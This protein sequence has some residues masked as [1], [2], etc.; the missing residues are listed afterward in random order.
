MG[1]FCPSCGSGTGE[2]ARFCSKCGYNLIITD[3]IQTASGE[4]VERKQ[5]V[6]S[7]S[8]IETPRGLKLLPGEILLERHLDYYISNKRLIKHV[9][10]LIS[11]KTEDWLLHHIKGTQ[12]NEDKPFLVPGIGIGVLCILLSGLNAM[13]FFFGLLAII[14]AL[15]YKTSELEIRHM[16]GSSFQIPDIHA[17]GE[18]F[19]KTFKEVFYKQGPYT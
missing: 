8:P 6:F 4:I 14:V 1:K 19:L 5:E 16:D 3:K 17:G 2:D 9:P 11:S 15:S 13:F 10:S 18:N 12:L 7:K